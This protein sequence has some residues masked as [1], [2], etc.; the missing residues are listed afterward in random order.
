MCASKDSKT[1]EFENKSVLPARWESV[2]VI[3]EV[4]RSV[5]CLPSSHCFDS[6]QSKFPD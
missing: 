2:F 6:I 4:C 5:L 1:T 3:L